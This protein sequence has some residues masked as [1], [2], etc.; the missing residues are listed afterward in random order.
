MKLFFFFMLV[1]SA[2]ASFSQDLQAIEKDLLNKYQKIFYW[3]NYSEKEDQISK[4][5]S[6]SE[7]NK[8][9]QESL[10]VT[11]SIPS[12]FNYDFPLLKNERLTIATSG[13]KLFRIYSWDTWKGGTMHFFDNVFQYKEGKK[14]FSFASRDSTTDEDCGVFYSDLYT[15]KTN[16]QTYYLAID[17]AILSTK[18]SYQGVNI[19]TIRNNM[20]K[21]AKLFKTKTGLNTSLG[22]EFNF[23][24]VVD[25]PE[26]PVKLIDYNSKTKTL[27][28]PV[29]LEDGKVTN[30]W[31]TYQFTGKYFER[32][33]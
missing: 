2:R 6:L 17:H 33:K 3:Y 30:R 21:P 4:Y 1:L 9:F 27:K 28:I 20:L 31:I 16:G 5:D 11:T 18:D 24:S 8:K 15:L 25:R 13:D 14:V 23:F 19:F 32:K 26:R 7:V 22:F 29:V 10:L 12:S